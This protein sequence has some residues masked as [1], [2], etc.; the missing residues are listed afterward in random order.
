MKYFS[1]NGKYNGYSF[2]N[3]SIMFIFVY[4]LCVKNLIFSHDTLKVGLKFTS[5]FWSPT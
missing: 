2:Y 1:I 3:R 4:I 5:H